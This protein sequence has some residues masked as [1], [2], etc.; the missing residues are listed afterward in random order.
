M[1]SYLTIKKD[2][3]TIGCWSRSEEMYQALSCHCS[4]GN[5]E[6]FDPE[7]EFT[8]VIED[9]KIEITSID[10]TIKLYEKMLEG[11]LDYE[12]RFQTISAMQDYEKLKKENEILIIQIQF[13]LRMYNDSI[14]DSDVD[15]E[16]N[17]WTWMMD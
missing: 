5:W 13:M 12:E 3:V 4:Y 9:I 15:Q 6:T 16:R 8:Y 14:Y 1:S 7:K 10:E 11:K 2:G 17:I